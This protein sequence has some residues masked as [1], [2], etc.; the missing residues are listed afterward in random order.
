M[1][2]KVCHMTSAHKRY[3]VRILEKQCVS[4]A[5]RGYEVTLIVNDD[6]KDEVYKNVKIVST[7]IQPRDRRERLLKS[8]QKIYEKALAIDADL[9][10][11]HDPDLLTLAK[12]LKKQGK[13]VIFDSHEDVPSHIQTKSW[14]PGPLRRITGKAYAW[15]EKQV[16][17]KLD[18]VIS[19]TPHIV[20]RLSK[21]NE[22]A[23]MITNY[24]V[25]ETNQE[26]LEQN[27][28]PKE[29]KGVCFA[30]G[31]TKQWNHHNIIEA[32]EELD[33]IRYYLA[34][35]G[36]EAYINELQQ[37]PGWEKV[38][39]LGRI[40]H[41][42]VKGLYQKSQAGVA[43]NYAEQV[44]AQGTLGNTKLFEY[45][46][47]KLP[48]ICSDYGLWKEIVDKYQCGLTINPRDK[49]AIKDAIQWIVDHPREAK[50]MGE[51]GYRGIQEEYNWKTQEDRLVRFYEKILSKQ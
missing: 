10:Q 44:K 46:A 16:V 33:G 27:P 11:F 30:G 28:L 39:F 24:P 37:Q 50:N 8:K 47:A 48:V 20:E 42:E 29:G 23:V 36:N 1:K 19:V 32:L 40:P 3:D 17:R 15:Y 26:A 13:K 41:G 35:G 9:Y 18:G 22:N 25:L 2:T 14:I 4:L 7:M 49:E 21:I 45:M 6:L 51:K 5:N 12:K 34:G 31:I 38:Q 43:L